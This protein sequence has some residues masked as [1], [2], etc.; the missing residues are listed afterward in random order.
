M[1]TVETETFTGDG[2]LLF[3]KLKEFLLS[4]GSIYL[5]EDTMTSLEDTTELP[6]FVRGRGVLVDNTENLETFMPNA[7]R[8][9][10]S[11]LLS[12]IAPR[13][14]ELVRVLVL[15]E[16]ERRIDIDTGQVERRIVGT[17]FI[18]I[19]FKYCIE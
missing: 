5:N 6:R 4:C 9:L 11:S 16:T 19:E 12:R 15:A 1:Q 14:D 8:Q 17:H 13:Q 10:V 2:K 18:E 7:T 3:Y